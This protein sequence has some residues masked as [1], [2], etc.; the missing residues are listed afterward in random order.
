MLIYLKGYSQ[1]EGLYSSDSPDL[2]RQWY[3]CT[4]G[5]VF[6]AGR[7]FGAGRIRFEFDS[8]LPVP[9]IWSVLHLADD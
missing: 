5:P 7:P 1:S 4:D 8:Q 6:G 3:Q 9:H 2:G